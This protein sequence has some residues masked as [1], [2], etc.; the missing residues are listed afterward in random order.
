[1]LVA[2]DADGDRPLGVG[3][4]DVESFDNMGPQGVRKG[5]QRIQSNWRMIQRGG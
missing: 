4:S 1:M 2:S 5:V 3:E